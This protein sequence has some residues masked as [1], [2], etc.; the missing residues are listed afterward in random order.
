[1][2]MA[3]R[4]SVSSTKSSNTAVT[5]EPLHAAK[6]EAESTRNPVQEGSD[7]ELC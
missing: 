6:G 5:R 4:K 1:M 7:P 3:E 2:K